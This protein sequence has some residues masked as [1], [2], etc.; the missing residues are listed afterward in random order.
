MGYDYGIL[1]DYFF[2][3]SRIHTQ[4]MKWEKQ[5]FVRNV[6]VLLGKHEMTKKMAGRDKRELKEE[7]G[8]SIGPNRIV[9]QFSRVEELLNKY[10]LQYSWKKL[11]SCIK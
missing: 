1:G 9:R 10:L 8:V 11:M 3:E 5:E 6:N 7:L 2:D 4:Q